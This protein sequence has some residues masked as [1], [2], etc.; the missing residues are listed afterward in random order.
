M[1]AETKI[2]S[3]DDDDAQDDDPKDDPSGEDDHPSG[4]GNDPEDDPPED[5]EPS[6]QEDDESQIPE[7]IKDLDEEEVDAKTLQRFIEL[8]DEMTEWPPWLELGKIRIVMAISSDEEGIEEGQEEQ[9]Q[10]E[11]EEM[12]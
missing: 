3:E 7:P 6:D 11:K 10:G 2:S 8:A 4:E 1:M 12:W 5:E 9:T